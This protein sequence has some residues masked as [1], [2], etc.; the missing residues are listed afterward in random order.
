MEALIVINGPIAAGKSTLARVLAQHL[1]EQGHSTAA[2]DLDELY[3]MMSDAGPMADATTW[4]RA[5][6]AAQ[7]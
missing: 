3:F 2:L 5:R 7:R 4:L 6:R 1:R